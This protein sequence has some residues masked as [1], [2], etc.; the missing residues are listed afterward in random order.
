MSQFPGD[1]SAL[2][3]KGRALREHGRLEEAAA[4]LAQASAAYPFAGIWRDEARAPSVRGPY[5]FCFGDSTRT[6]LNGC[7]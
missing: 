5:Q 7:L 2:H 6:L 3:R 4:A 1:A